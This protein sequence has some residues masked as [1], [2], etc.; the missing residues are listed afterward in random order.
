MKT[1]EEIAESLGLESGCQDWGIENADG[2]RVSEFIAFYEGIF[3]LAQPQA[4]AMADLVLQSAQEAIDSG[5]LSE[6]LL[7]QVVGFF[8]KHS[9][10][11]PVA[12]GYWLS[13]NE[14]E[15]PIAQLLHKAGASA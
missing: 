4:E 13:L 6:E 8:A 7:L 5:L 11:F 1:L 15:W 2:H 14:A 3:P 9:H 12:A 10:E